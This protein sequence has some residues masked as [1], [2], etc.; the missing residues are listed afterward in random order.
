MMPSPI[1]SNFS[2]TYCIF[3]SKVWTQQ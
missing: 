2:H 1:C 3:I